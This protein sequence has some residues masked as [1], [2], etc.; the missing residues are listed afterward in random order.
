MKRNKALAAAA[1]LMMLTGTLSGCSLGST[2]PQDLYGPPP[3]EE[4]TGNSRS[5]SS[6]DVFEDKTA[7]RRADEGQL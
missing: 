2:A 3:S 7:E 6:S 1:V 5:D 4:V